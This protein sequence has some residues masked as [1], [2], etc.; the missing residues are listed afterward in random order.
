MKNKNIILAILCFSIILNLDAQNWEY[1]HSIAGSDLG[2]NIVEVENGNYLISGRMSSQVSESSDILL[3]KLNSN[4]EFLWA[5]EFGFDALDSGYVVRPFNDGYLVCGIGIPFSGIGVILIKTDLDGNQVWLKT[6]PTYSLSPG[7]LMDVDEDGNIYIG[8]SH[9]NMS[10]GKIEPSILKLNDNGELIWAKSFDEENWT[11]N[12]G[13]ELIYTKD[14]TLIFS[15]SGII[16]D[17]TFIVNKFEK[18]LSLNTSGII[19]SEYIIE[20]EIISFL[21][22]VNMTY[23]KA[24]EIIIAGIQD[25]QGAQRLIKLDMNNAE[26][27][28]NKEIS[29][30]VNRTRDITTLED[31]GIG[32]ISDVNFSSISDILLNTYDSNGNL[33][34]TEIF[35]FGSGEEGRSIIKNANGDIVIAGVIREDEFNG[36]GLLAFE[37]SLEDCLISSLDDLEG[38][39]SMLKISPNPTSGI[40]EIKNYSPYEMEIRIYNLIGNK[41]KELRLNPEMNI[42]CDLS[43]ISK[44]MYLVSYSHKDGNDSKIS[45]IIVN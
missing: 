16:E 2:R 44:G 9:N 36:L 28:W 21:D 43:E 10:L 22:Y 14:G 45:K 32:I 27:L 41:I 19:L 39:K 11:S 35:D 18:F 34:T 8:A 42:S 1:I 31:E 6:F 37:T 30:P 7:D 40:L 25:N 17:S 29:I 3:L 24:K 13:N 23:I 5:K 15:I 26:E 33:C 12:Y 20:N 38:E 4:G